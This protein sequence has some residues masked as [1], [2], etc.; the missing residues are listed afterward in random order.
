MLQTQC[1]KQ[2]KEVISKLCIKL[3]G[4]FPLTVNTQIEN[5]PFVA[6]DNTT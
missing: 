6:Q 4:V 5:M 1:E 2:V 3:K